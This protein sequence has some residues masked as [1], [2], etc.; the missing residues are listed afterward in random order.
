M[1][2]GRGKDNI[3]EYRQL[4]SPC[5]MD[6]FNCPAFLANEDMSVKRGISERFQLPLEAAKCEGC[7]NAKGKIS[8]LGDNEPCDIFRCTSGKGI[9]YCF[10]CTEFPCDL[11]HPHADQASTRPHNTKL[12]NLCLI[13]NMGL[14][15]WAKNKA[16]N[17]RKKY[18]NDKLRV[19]A[20][21]NKE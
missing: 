15:E 4:T 7:R 3:M 6:C 18:F 12:F 5:G 21:D 2:A 20:A 14:D 16:L 11:L 17:V 13:K 19:H 8:F 1:G 9:A 10:E